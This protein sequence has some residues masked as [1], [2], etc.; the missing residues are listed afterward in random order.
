MDI[1]VTKV[2]ANESLTRE[3]LI[4]MLEKNAGS[5]VHFDKPV[6]IV[7]HF[8]MQ[9]EDVQSIEKD[10]SADPNTF[11]A[12]LSAELHDSSGDMVLIDGIDTSRYEGGIMPL[13]SNHDNTQIA[14]TINKLYKTP[15]TYKGEKVRAMKAVVTL[16]DTQYGQYWKTVKA[17]GLPM[18]LSIGALVKE[19]ELIKNKKDQTTGILYK[20]IEMIEGSA[21]AVP[22]NPAA[23][24][25]KS[26]DSDI[27]THEDIEM[28]KE[29]LDALNAKLDKLVEQNDK[30]AKSLDVT[31][32]RLDE[33]VSKMT[34]TPAPEKAKPAADDASNKQAEADLAKKL[35][36]L[37]E[38]FKKKS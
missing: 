1:K 11:T 37:L 36:D 19:A 15:I 7:K 28:T 23:S 22:A 10:A 9:S 2:E 34:I 13:L 31:E 4:A 5:S 17:S 29:Q 25:Q 18:R 24:E 6:S 35:H 12:V 32:D 26:I 20:K 33:L 38:K 3:Q 27:V 30:F 14:G 16:N 8:N 21:V